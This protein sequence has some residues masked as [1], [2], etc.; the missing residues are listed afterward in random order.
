[1]SASESATLMQSVTTVVAPSVPPPATAATDT[2]MPQHSFLMMDESPSMGSHITGNTVLLA[3]STGS[4]SNV[5]T[6]TLPTTA[7]NATRVPP[8]PSLEAASALR[9]LLIEGML[10]LQAL[11]HQPEL[12]AFSFVDL[13]QVMQNGPD[14]DW[15]EV[16]TI[17][18]IERALS[19]PMST[20]ALP[21]SGSISSS[22]SS[23]S[24]SSL[25]A[26]SSVVT[27]QLASSPQLWASLPRGRDGAH[28]LHI[29]AAL[30]YTHLILC[31]LNMR[32]QIDCLDLH[33]R[34]PLHYA[35]AAGSVRAIVALLSH[36][37]DD[38]VRDKDG[39]TAAEL[40]Q[41]CGMGD[42]MSM[43]VDVGVSL[44]PAD[45]D[46]QDEEL[47]LVAPATAAMVDLSPKTLTGVGTP[48]ALNAVSIHDT[49]SP[50]AGADSNLV[51]RLG[52]EFSRLTL[53][54]IG[55][56]SADIDQAM[57]QDAFDQAVVRIQGQVRAWLVR[58]H[59]AARILQGATRRWLERKYLKRRHDDAASGSSSSNCAAVSITPFQRLKQATLV[60]QRLFRER[61]KLGM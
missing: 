31:L 8:V 13:L 24:S 23:S 6:L 39:L 60:V 47:V 30:G 36:G 58:R 32:A 44:P 50:A 29:G 52:V 18:S 56:S 42:V 14:D 43:V 33:G 37:A 45:D 21:T 26:S 46:D 53:E 48:L 34:T 1:M 61:H 17:K 49:S 5:S 22:S 10:Q 38:T 40:A 27:A 59:E 54:Q 19:V 12:T 25:P 4:P 20:P 55:I 57:S 2:M 3:S 7:G 51:S 11:V 9:S 16:L 35:A 15:L 41:L 28:L